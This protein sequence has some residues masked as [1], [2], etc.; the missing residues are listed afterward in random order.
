MATNDSTVVGV[1]ACQTGW[2]LTV[3]E[4]GE[5]RMDR[6]G[7][8][9]EN[10]ENHS[11]ADRILVDIPIGL[12]KDERRQCDITARDLLGSRGVSV[13]YPP[14]RSAVD[15][16][17]YQEASDKHREK[18]GHGHSQQAHS[19]SQKIR[20]VAE[21][22]DPDD[23]QVYESHPEL[24]FAALNGQPVAYSK[25]SECGRGIRMKLLSDELDSA[26]KCYQQAR[27]TYLLK[28]VRRDDIL[29]S[30]V[31]VVAARDR[32]L[33]KIPSDVSS[34]DPR[35]YYPEFEVPTAHF[36]QASGCF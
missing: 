26:K 36:E 4:N 6:V 32:E 22:V 5:P 3:V 30:M 23:D 29:D 34:I 28:E 1:D 35:I 33:T 16:D 10:I 13:F 12:P 17:E 11:E 2:F 20:E 15:C 31:L 14:C 9:S 8:F 21:M 27:D 24:C 7:A 25:S 19:I 18:V